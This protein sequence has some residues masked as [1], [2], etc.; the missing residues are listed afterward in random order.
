MAVFVAFKHETNGKVVSLECPFEKLWQGIR[1]EGDWPGQLRLRG[2]GPVKA[3]LTEVTL[4]VIRC[5]LL[6]FRR[7]TMPRKP[8]PPSPGPSPLV[9]FWRF[10]SWSQQASALPSVSRRSSKGK[11]ADSVRTKLFRKNQ[12][13]DWACEPAIWR[14]PHCYIVISPLW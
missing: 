12:P 4:G 2:V 3:T 8:M 13:G 6:S 7:Q 9:S 5:D 10:S 11:G 1:G 14:T